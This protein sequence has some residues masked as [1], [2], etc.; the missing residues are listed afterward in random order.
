MLYIFLITAV[1][2]SSNY[3]ILIEYS[4]SKRSV[5]NRLVLSHHGK[6]S[7]LPTEKAKEMRNIR[8][9]VK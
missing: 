1:Y 4:I 9:I 5:V 3:F 2:F 7:I 8:Y 6:K